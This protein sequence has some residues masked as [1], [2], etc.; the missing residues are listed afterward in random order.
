MKPLTFDRAL[1]LFKKLARDKGIRSYAQTFLVNADTELVYTDGHIL[2]KVACGHSLSSGVYALNGQ[3]SPV[4]YPDIRALIESTKNVELIKDVTPL[5]RLATLIKPATN[6]ELVIVSDE[7]RIDADS[8]INLKYL[9]MLPDLGI[10]HISKHGD[11][12][13]GISP[14]T[15]TTAYIAGCNK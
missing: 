11:L 14:Q 3:P 10:T 15:F 1:T 9:S 8:G 4:K 7:G 6:R 12:Y 5:M 2:L 13:V